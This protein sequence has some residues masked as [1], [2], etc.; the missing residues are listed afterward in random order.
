MR[1]ER[2][3]LLRTLPVRVVPRPLLLLVQCD[4]RL[5]AAKPPLVPTEQAIGE[6][7]VPREHLSVSFPGEPL[8][9]WLA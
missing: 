3:L 5:Q 4:P 1:S 7:Q 9:T 2:R 8:L 6:G